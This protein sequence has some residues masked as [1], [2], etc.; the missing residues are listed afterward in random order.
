MEYKFHIGQLVRIGNTCPCTDR[1]YHKRGRVVSL[2][3]GRYGVIIV[4]MIDPFIHGETHITWCSNDLWEPCPDVICCE[5][6][7]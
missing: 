2:N 1:N 6:L 4:D 5:S 3:K 7:L